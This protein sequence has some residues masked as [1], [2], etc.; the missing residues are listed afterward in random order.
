MIARVWRANKGTLRLTCFYFSCSQWLPEIWGQ[1]RELCC[2]PVTTFRDC[3]SLEGKREL[4]AANLLLFFMLPVIARVWRAT[5]GT[6]L[7]LTCYYFSCSQW[8][9]EFW[10]QTRELWCLPV[11]TFRD[12]RSLEGNQGNHMLLTC[13]Y[14]SCSLWLPEFGVKIRELYHAALWHLKNEIMQTMT[15]K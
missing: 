2:L 15:K 5:K 14:F 1:T 3:G 9:P 13:Y 12:C 4:Y 11:T 7:L 10:G 8:L 6:M